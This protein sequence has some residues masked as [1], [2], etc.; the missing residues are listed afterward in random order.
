MTKPTRKESEAVAF[1]KWINNIKNTPM[2][3]A[4]QIYEAIGKGYGF[5]GS[6]EQCVKIIN[7]ILSPPYKP[8]CD[9]CN[10]KFWL[11]DENDNRIGGCICHYQ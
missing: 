2:T 9:K 11:Y 7:D 5:N 8:K 1:T 6:K 3:K 4:E 10:D